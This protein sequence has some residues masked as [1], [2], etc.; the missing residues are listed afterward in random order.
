MPDHFKWLLVGDFNLY[1]SPTDRNRPGEDIDQMLLFNDAISALGLVELPLKGRRFTWTNKQ[2]PPFLECLDWFFTSTCW[3]LTYPS[4]FV[5]PLVIE[6]SDH[7]PCVVIIDTTIPKHSIFRFE[8]YWME[9]QD[10]FSVVQNGWMAP[11][12]IVD[13]ARII[14]AKF[15]NLRSVLKVWQRGLSNLKVVIQ[16]VKLTLSL[17]LLV[18]ELEILPSQG[19]TSSFFLSRNFL[20]Q[21]HL[22]WKQ[23]G[24]VKWV[25]LGDASTKFFHANATAK[26]RRNLISVLEDG[27]GN[28]LSN[29][30]DKAT[31]I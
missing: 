20:H 5:Y 31:L 14:T 8:N 9:H 28:L 2:T 30:D 19:G 23:R 27:N 4:S 16:N 12:H 21:Q 29:H 10:F 6:T 3:T 7:V 1:R 24:T 25:T 17:I 15:K 26:Y 18:E 11:S 22:Y 13:L